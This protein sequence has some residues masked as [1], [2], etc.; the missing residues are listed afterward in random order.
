MMIRLF[1]WKRSDELPVMKW[2]ICGSRAQLQPHYPTLSYR[3]TIQ[4]FSTT[5]PRIRGESQWAYLKLK[6]WT[7]TR[8]FFSLY[9]PSSLSSHLHYEWEWKTYN[10]THISNSCAKFSIR[11]FNFS[12]EKP[13]CLTYKRTIKPLWLSLQTSD[14]A[15]K[16]TCYVMSISD[17]TV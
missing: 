3:L 6:L 16:A 15:Q 17:S 11:P 8:T 1:F 2:T 14:N 10:W 9:N 12:A 13:W 7:S 5:L 4:S